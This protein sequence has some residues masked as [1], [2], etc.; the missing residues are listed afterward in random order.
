MDELIE[1][2]RTVQQPP[3]WLY[4]AVPTAVLLPFWLFVPF[5]PDVL[6]HVLLEGV[7]LLFAAVIAVFVRRLGIGI[8]EVGWLIFILSRTIDFVDELYV[9]AEPVVEPYLSGFLMVFSF[10]ILL[11]GAVTLLREQNERLTELTARNRELELKNTAIQEAP[12]GITI[13]DMTTEGEPLVAVNDGF[14]RMTGYDAEKV[15]GTNCRFLQGED[16]ADEPVAEMREAIDNGESIQRT[17][18]NYRKDGTQ[19][20]NEI[21]L[22]PIRRDGEVKNYV[23][24]QQE[25]TERVEYENQLQTER[26]N[27]RLLSQLVRHD[28]RNDLQIIQLHLDL[29]TEHVDEDGEEHLNTV[30]NCAQDAID[31][32]TTA[33]E[34]SETMREDEREQK[35]VSITES[36]LDEITE[37]RSRFEDAAIEQ[38][39]SFPSVIIEA[40]EMLDSVFRNLLKNAVQ[41]NDTDHPEV[42]VS[43]TQSE[44]T[45]TV[46]IADNGPGIPDEKKA[47]IFA[48]GKQGLDSDGTGIG[49]HLVETLV[50]RYGGTVWIE[51]NE[52]RGAVFVT[53]FPV[54]DEDVPLTAG[55]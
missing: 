33:K 39:D 55:L 24:F 13:A 25:A 45:V 21:V 5:S 6:P 46:R 38:S 34:L 22:A 3:L 20:W 10:S 11:A 27:S 8:L 44:E 52:P 1:R 7:Y 29:L 43:M 41:H 42:T 40:D 18:R 14:T 54:S 48:E 51:D 26:D 19:F 50:N 4:F 16:T 9:E 17:I 35:P 36:L 2:F 31:L 32:T 28:I 30:L 12:I 53:E 23:G 37:I 47:T 49:T 15:V